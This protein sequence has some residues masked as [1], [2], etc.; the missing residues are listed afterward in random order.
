MGN[1]VDIDPLK[2]TMDVI[3]KRVELGH[4][5]FPGDKYSAGPAARPAFSL[6]V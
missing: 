2:V 6:V 4:R 5:V 1:L 3:G